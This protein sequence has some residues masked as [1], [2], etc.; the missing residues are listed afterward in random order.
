M[1]GKTV[2]ARMDSVV[3]CELFS[4][5]AESRRFGREMLLTKRDLFAWTTLCAVTSNV[6]AAPTESVIS[7]NKA[8]DVIDLLRTIKERSRVHLEPGHYKFS[9]LEITQEGL[10]LTGLGA[11]VTVT[12]GVYLKGEGISL[13]GITFIECPTRCVI[14]ESSNIIVEDCTFQSMGHGFAD[15]SYYSS[16]I[17]ILSP[18]MRATIR[19]CRFML[20]DCIQCIR[21][22]TSSAHLSVSGNFCRA[23]WGAFLRVA[24]GSARNRIVVRHN[25]IQQIGVRN[26]ASAVGATAIYCANAQEGAVIQNRIADVAENGIEGPWGLIAY[27]LVERCGK[28]TGFSSYATSSRFGI[29]AFS[30]TVIFSN[31]ISHCGDREINVYAEDGHAID[32]LMI[33]RNMIQG[34][35]RDKA[36]IYIS[37]SSPA[38]RLFVGKNYCLP[39]GRIFWRVPNSSSYHVEEG[40]G[41]VLE[42]SG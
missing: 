41:L 36:V 32:N 10:H 21:V 23:T 15:N 25:L 16:C 34:R 19:R 37:S 13:S 8:E 1:V 6:S 14:V 9:R 18:C 20:I 11:L 22:E 29:S 30:N 33:L 28:E 7:V 31:I 35:V 12:D 39:R 26:A 2:A 40:N 17:H 24:L 4:W 27:N 38:R 3:T 5:H 42:I